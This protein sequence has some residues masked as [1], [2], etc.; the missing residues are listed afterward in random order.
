[1]E[2]KNELQKERV[3][4]GSIWGVAAIIAIIGAFWQ[5][6][7]FFLAVLCGIM[8]GIFFESYRNNKE[9]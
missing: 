8:S 1:M 2:I 4:L 6:A 7:A 3:F 5:F 9:N